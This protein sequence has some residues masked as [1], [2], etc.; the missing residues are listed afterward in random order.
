MMIALEMSCIRN[1]PQKYKKNICQ[2]RSNIMTTDRNKSGPWKEQWCHNQMPVYL[3]IGN[4]WEREEVFTTSN[5]KNGS[6]NWCGNKKSLVGVPDSETKTVTQTTS[7][8]Q[9]K[10]DPEIKTLV[11]AVLRDHTRNQ[12]TDETS[13]DRS[14]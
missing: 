14:V 1:L 8:H 12:E 3:V 5:Q 11:K 13:V 4:K 7:S 2:V 10:L 6:S 9:F